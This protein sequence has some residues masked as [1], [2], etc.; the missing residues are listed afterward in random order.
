MDDGFFSAGLILLLE[1]LSQRRDFST[2]MLHMGRVA[3]YYSVYC[4]YCGVYK[5]KY[6]SR[7][8][9]CIGVKIRY[10]SV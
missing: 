4:K 2:C 9:K 6:S 5:F 7:R 8:R 10:I 1:P 3:L